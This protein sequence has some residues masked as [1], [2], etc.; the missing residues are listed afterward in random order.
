MFQ[1]TGK[2]CLLA[3][4]TYCTVGERS[5]YRTS[6]ACRWVA[7]ELKLPHL[8][9]GPTNE[10]RRF[11]C[12]RVVLHILPRIRFYVLR[13]GSQWVIKEELERRTQTLLYHVSQHTSIREISS[14]RNDILSK[15][16]RG[17]VSRDVDTKC[18]SQSVRI[19][20]REE[21]PHHSTHSADSSPD[22]FSPARKYIV[23]AFAVQAVPCHVGGIGIGDPVFLGTTK[24]A[25]RE[26]PN[27]QSNLP[28]GLR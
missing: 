12:F 16:V 20:N 9:Y 14:P 15:C 28:Q 6:S 23:S 10:G 19:C 13:S 2:E 5:L 18:A 11:M 7:T 17:S 27:C 8:H 21:K 22:A 4:Y 1:R 24:Y 25:N 26:E 3:P